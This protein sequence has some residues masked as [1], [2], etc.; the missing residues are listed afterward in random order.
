[1]AAQGARFDSLEWFLFTRQERNLEKSSFITEKETESNCAAFD[2][3][4]T[5]I[6][7]QEEEFSKEERRDGAVSAEQ[8]TGKGFIDLLQSSKCF[9]IYSIIYL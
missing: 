6:T 8:W 9:N 1:M 5:V 7:R 2:H 3:A 4:I